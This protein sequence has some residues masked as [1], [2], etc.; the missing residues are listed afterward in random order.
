M[1]YL[2][3]LVGVLAAVAAKRIIDVRQLAA[4]YARS[5]EAQR[6]AQPEPNTDRK[7]G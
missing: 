2:Y 3:L 1:D 6:A 4:R 7:N 5:L